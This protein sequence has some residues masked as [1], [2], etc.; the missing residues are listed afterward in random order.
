MRIAPLLALSTGLT[1]LAACQ[2]ADPPGSAPVVS[3]ATIAG[4]YR[5]T[6]LDDTPA[7]LPEPMQAAITPT[8]I[9]VRSGCV[10]FA[11]DYQ[12]EGDVLNLTPA[13]VPSCRRALLPAEQKVQDVLATGPTITRL[14]DESLKVGG[15][16]ASFVLAPG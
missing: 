8:R 16:T 7:D 11:F 13:P 14:A 4:E 9:D 10:R 3:A 1:L 5:V 15:A 12:L 6:T 2:P